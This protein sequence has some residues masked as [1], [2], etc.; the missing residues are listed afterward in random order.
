MLVTS[1]NIESVGLLH[2]RRL[3]HLIV[4][5]VVGVGLVRLGKELVLGPEVGA[6]E[7]VRL[8]EGVEAR[9]DEV[10][11]GAGVPLGRGVHVVKASEAEKLLHGGGRN[12]AGTAGCR[13]EADAHRAALA[14]EL[15]RHRVRGAGHLAPVPAADR[16]DVHLG[17]DNSAAD[18]GGHLLSALDA[19]AEVAGAIAHHDAAAESGALAGRGLLLHRHDLHNLVLARLAQDLVDDLELLDRHGEEENLLEALDL[20][21]LYEA[22][23]LG[24]RHPLLVVAATAAL[25]LAFAL[26]LS[27]A[28]AITLAL[29]ATAETSAVAFAAFHWGGSISHD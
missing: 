18:G 19:E 7:A 4:H 23:E 10:A 29:A 25:A 3:L 11:D 27:L 12:E 2:V 1:L 14:H 8:L 24:A 26:A 9:L 28:L 6:Q 5:E 20:A 15:V 16:A 13:N 22:A 21:V 17:G